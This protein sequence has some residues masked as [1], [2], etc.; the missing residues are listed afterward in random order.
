MNESPK[1][2]TSEQASHATEMLLDRLGLTENPFAESSSG[3]FFVGGQR[4]FLVQQAVHALY[5]ASGIVL[6][7]GAEGA[8]KTRIVDEVCLEM[9]ELADICRLQASVMMDVI[10][11]RQ[12]LVQQLGLTADPA[13]QDAFM[14]ALQQLQPVEGDPLPVLLVIDDAHELAVPVLVACRELAEASGG[15]IR[16]LL[17]GAPELLKAWEQTGQNSID[18]L[19]VLPLDKQE[20]VDYV[21]T[22]LQ[23]AGYR[24]ENPLSDVQQEELYRHTRGNISAIH[25]VVPSLLLAA[26][27]GDE[28]TLSK[29]RLPLPHLLMAG[30]LVGVVGVAALLWR[31]GGGTEPSSPIVEPASIEGRQSVPLSL[32]PAPEVSP[33]AAVAESSPV[34]VEPAREIQ[35]AAAAPKESVASDKVPAVTTIAQMPA[36]PVAAPAVS[37]APVEPS[38]ATA[39]AAPPAKTVAAKTKPAAKPVAIKPAKTSAAPKGLANMSSNQYVVQLMALSTKPKLDAYIKKTATG[40]K[41]EIYETRRNGKPWFVAVTGPYADQNAARA[42]ITKLPKSLQDQHP[43]LRSVASVKADLQHK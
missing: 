14:T 27:G 16:L 1:H 2:A 4:R 42:A 35:Q 12:R 36:A 11:I 15:R 31:S 22:R 24:G 6:M 25:A 10:E 33:A 39:K 19:D 26:S 29:R 3:F 5:F 34:H 41:V 18:Q 32:P 13:D 20:T 28:S 23:A 8:G 43:W 38:V 17:A 21:A 30:V 37:P 9:A 7:G 40:I